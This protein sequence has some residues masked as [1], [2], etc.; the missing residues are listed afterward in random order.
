MSLIYITI[1][2]DEDFEYFLARA[3]PAIQKSLDESAAMVADMTVSRAKQIVPVRTGTLQRSIAAKRLAV[4]YYA[5][6]SVVVYAPFVEFGTM[7]MRPQ[8]FL[9]PAMAE[10]AL[11]FPDLFGDALRVNWR[12]FA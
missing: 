12:G 8:P 10:M 2:G 9:R 4:C 11:R 6:G 3:A 1:S 7:F 5:V